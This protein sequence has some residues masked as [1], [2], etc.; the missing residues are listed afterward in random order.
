MA[1]KLLEQRVTFVVKKTADGMIKVDVGFYPP[2]A[3]NEEKFKKLSQEMQELQ[4]TTYSIAN[5]AMEAMM[6]KDKKIE[7]EKNGTSDK[8]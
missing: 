4:S 7:E 2:M 5:F 1:K 8:S 6:Q 3:G